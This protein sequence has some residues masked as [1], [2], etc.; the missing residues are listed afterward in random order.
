MADVR[1]WLPTPDPA[2]TPDGPRRLAIPEP[3]TPPDRLPPDAARALAWSIERIFTEDHTGRLDLPATVERSARAA[4]FTPAWDAHRQLREVWLWGDFG[5]SGIQEYIF[6][7]QETLLRAGIEV[8][9]G[10]FT[11]VP[12]EVWWVEGDAQRWRKVELFR[13]ATVEGRR[14][15]AVVGILADGASWARAA[16]SARSSELKF[17]IA[18][19]ADWPRLAFAD[20][21]ADLAAQVEPLSCVAPDQLPTA[22]GATGIEVQVALDPATLLDWKGGLALAG[23]SVAETTGLALRQTLG[24]PGSAVAWREVASGLWRC[25]PAQRPDLV[26]R[27]RRVQPELFEQA[28]LFWLRL[29]E[30]EQQ[31]RRADRSLP[32]EGSGAVLRLRMELALLWLWEP[33]RVE[34]AAAELWKIA[35]AGLAEEL[36]ERLRWYG[37][38][39]SGT[40]MGLDLQKASPLAIHMLGELGMPLTRGTLAPPRRL[41]WARGMALWA[42]VVAT[43]GA[44]VFLPD[45]VRPEPPDAAEGWTISAG[46]LRLVTPRISRQWSI[47]WFQKGEFLVKEEEGAAED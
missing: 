16:G 1:R 19:L 18:G 22:L 10:I 30:R 45:W 33:G 23:E 41:L 24:I 14:E 35:G 26:N 31:Q 6:E 37:P 20:F 3:E 34:E 21:G 4:T 43:F 47:G 9:I 13:P 44:M 2:P 15:T 25:T 8:R 7:L 42:G 28:R 11:G 29:R 40:Q 39:A 17:L 27:L 12:L 36:R 5:V 38:Q 46:E 32:W